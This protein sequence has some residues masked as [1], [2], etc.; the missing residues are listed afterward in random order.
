MLGETTILQR[1]L[2]CKTP[3]FACGLLAERQSLSLKSSSCGSLKWR[4][5]ASDLFLSLALASGIDVLG[6]NDTSAKILLAEPGLAS[7][8]GLRAACVAVS[9]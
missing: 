9:D 3:I 7:Q 4:H 5:E 2:K 1:C 6:G 8:R